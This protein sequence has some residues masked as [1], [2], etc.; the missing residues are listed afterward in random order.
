MKAF[1]ASLGVLILQN[2]KD[3]MEIGTMPTSLKSSKKGR[4]GALDAINRGRPTA[5]PS[6]AY[7]GI[8]L[9]IKLKLRH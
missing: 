1:T 6:R 8:A 2:V 3:D 5:G 9:H 7:E 4:Y